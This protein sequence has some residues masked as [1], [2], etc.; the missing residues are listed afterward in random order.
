[1]RIASDVTELVG[2]TPLVRL[3]RVTDGAGA[4]VLAITNGV[5]QSAAAA[6]PGASYG[7]VQRVTAT[8]V[9][10]E[11]QVAFTNPSYMQHAYRMKTDL[12]SVTRKLVAA[13]GSLE[14]YGPGLC[15]EPEA[16]DDEHRAQEVKRAEVRVTAPSEH[17]LQEV[18]RVVGKKID[19]RKFRRQPPREQ[20]DRQRKAVHLGEEREDEGR[21]SAQGSPVLACAG[22]REAECEGDEEQRVDDNQ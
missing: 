19:S 9:G 3:N 8:K 15:Q 16:T 22:T 14:E 1:M 12:G 7:A 6:V 4:T 2:N 20:V 18:P 21:V 17:H 13:L 5:L 10:D 11:V